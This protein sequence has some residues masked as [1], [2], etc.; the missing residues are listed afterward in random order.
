MGYTWS[1]CS[2]VPSHGYECFI[3]NR[4][5]DAIC[6][7]KRVLEVYTSLTKTYIYHREPKNRKATPNRHPLPPPT[8]PP[9]PHPYPPPYHPHSHHPT[10]PPP[11]T[12]TPPTPPNTPPPPPTPPLQQC[13]RWAKCGLMLRSHAGTIWRARPNLHIDICCRNKAH[14]YDPL[15]CR[16]YASSDKGYLLV[17]NGNGKLIEIMFF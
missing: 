8:P 2:F 15:V 3:H 12:P 1:Y 17:M 10:P 16:K 11:P 6:A 4:T 14:K 7:M 5:S 9:T 13:A